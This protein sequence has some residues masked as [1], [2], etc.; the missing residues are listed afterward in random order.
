M[1]SRRKNSKTPSLRWP[2]SCL[3]CLL[4]L[5]AGAIT[6]PHIPI[7]FC[8][9]NFARGSP[10]WSAEIRAGRATF[11]QLVPRPSRVSAGSQALFQ[12]RRVSNLYLK[13]YQEALLAYLLVEKDYPGQELACKAQGAGGRNLQVP[14]QGLRPGH[15]RLPETPRQRCSRT[16]RIQY[17]SP[18]PTFGSTTS[19]RPGS[20]SR[21]C[22]KTYPAQPPGARGRIPDRRGLFPRRQ[23]RGAEAAFRRWSGALAG[24][25]LRHRSPFRPGHGAGENREN[26]SKR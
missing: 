7:G 16:D 9:P 20:N 14:A 24:E 23:A 15:R 6:L 8:R 26:S 11:L 4:A 21:V 1:R 22:S 19:N 2:S 10:W 12:Q 18:T 5:L 13:K 17:E 3:F 25:S